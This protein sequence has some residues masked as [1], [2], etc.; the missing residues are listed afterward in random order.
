MI[1]VRVLPNPPL[2]E[3]ASLLRDAFAER[4]EEGLNFSCASFSADDLKNILAADAV[5][6]GAFDETNA[7]LGMV[8]LNNIL[9]RRKVNIAQHEYLAVA[10]VA[11]RKGVGSALFKE[12]VAQAKK[13]N[14][15][16]VLSDTAK[17]ATSSVK[18]HLKN[19]FIIFGDSHYAG[20][21]YRSFNFVLPTSWVGKLLCTKPFLPLL[22]KKLTAEH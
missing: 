4:L 21:S 8:V 13:R 9:C 3:L 5:V 18:F 12:L 20:R 2:E 15:D 11:K 1:E 19:G 14:I 7:L 17:E 16:I 22:R 6:I 10:P